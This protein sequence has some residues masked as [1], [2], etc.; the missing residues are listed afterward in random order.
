MATPEQK[1]NRT[2]SNDFRKSEAFHS[3]K[4]LLGEQKKEHGSAFVRSGGSVVKSSALKKKTGMYTSPTGSKHREGSAKHKY[5]EGIE[6][7]GKE[8]RKYGAGD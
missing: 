8:D 5:W 7:R 6:K 2:L 1:K 3:H 4:A